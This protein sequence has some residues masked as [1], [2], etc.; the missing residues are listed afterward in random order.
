MQANAII[1]D[2]YAMASRFA[3]AFAARNVRP[4]AVF[5]TARLLDWGT[6][7]PDL[8]ASVHFHTGDIE[9]LAATVK[10]YDPVCIVPG[11]EAGVELAAELTE[12]LLPALANVPG[13]APAQR[14][15]GLQHKALAE[16]G[17]PHLRNICSSDPAE[18]A[19]WI[20]ESG[21]SGRALVVKPPKS[22][23]TDNVYLIR[24][25]ASW[26]PCFDAI[27]GKVNQMGVVNESVMVMEFAEGPEFMVDLYSV[28]GR[29]GL[30]MVSSYRKYS[31]GNRLGIYDMGDTL[32]PADQRT[33]EL[34]GYAAQVADAV[35]IRN[36]SAHG[37]VILTP[38]GPR[39]VEIG[40][41]FS[42]G[43]MQVHQ[44][45]STGD[46][47]IDRAVRHYLDG[48]YEPCYRMV[49][50][51]R[52]VWLSA[53]SA[54]RLADTE[55]LETVRGLPTFVQA[56]LPQ[57]GTV[58]DRTVDVDSRL[59][60]VV[61]ASDDWASIDADYARIRELEAQLVFTPQ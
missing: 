59:G 31:R 2:P 26:R 24:P 19:N 10:C 5:S 11:N 35:G 46:S 57:P 12:R 27:L 14:D 8:W 53:H 16:A 6:W 41:R 58:V 32:D 42:G 50:P 7:T 36:A 22:A 44:Q 60:W 13:M 56:D 39:L 49:S 20:A 52:T 30:T 28:D 18:V 21:L 45:I 48:A 15:K 38:Q 40:S 33:A 23:G 43:C 9:A 34:H 4:V 51:T 3:T 54:G 29:H 55:M 25:G 17:V 1:V 47:Q 37:E 61:L